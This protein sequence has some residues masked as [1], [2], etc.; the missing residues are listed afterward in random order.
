M[1]AGDLGSEKKPPLVIVISEFDDGRAE[2][3]RNEL[4]EK[5]VTLTTRTNPIPPSPFAGREENY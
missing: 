3:V 5:G 4:K 1:C 2:L